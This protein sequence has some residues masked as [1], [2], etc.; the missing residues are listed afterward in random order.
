MTIWQAYSALGIGMCLLTS[1]A[2]TA[3][4]HHSHAMYEV[5][6]IARVE[7]VVTS[8]QFA[9]PHVYLF[10]TVIKRDGKPATYPVEMSDTQRLERNGIGPVTFKPGDHV[11]IYVN[12]LRSGA[13]GG[14]YVGA[15][16][17]QGHKHGR[18]F[19][20]RRTGSPK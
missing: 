15:L 12:P 2:L 11:T 1:T 5:D 19:A 16:D 3:S 8:Y 14:S 18:Y 20:Q 13:L 10:L 7:G 9:N 17:A 4:A 6:R